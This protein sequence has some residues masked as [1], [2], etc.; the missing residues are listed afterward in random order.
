MDRLHQYTVYIS[1]VSHVEMFMSGLGRMPG[2]FTISSRAAGAEISLS[3]ATS[4]KASKS[5][6]G[7]HS[8]KGR[9]LFGDFFFLVWGFFLD[10]RFSP[11]SMLF[12]AFWS[13]K[14]PFPRYVQRF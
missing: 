4:L 1:C 5:L 10:F 7:K 12:A 11:F 6:Q 14:L 8:Q 3:T 13:W 9:K 2:A